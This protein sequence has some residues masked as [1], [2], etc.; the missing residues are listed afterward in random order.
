MNVLLRSLV[1]LYLRP[2]LFSSRRYASCIFQANQKLYRE[3]R[4][5][6]HGIKS[7]VSG[8]NLKAKPKNNGASIIT[9]DDLDVIEGKRDQLSGKLQQRY[10]YAKEEADRH[11]DE[12]EKSLTF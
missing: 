2:G 10:G 6:W 9:D 8:N 3:R 5:L 1:R 12:W 4:P 7:Q 11:I